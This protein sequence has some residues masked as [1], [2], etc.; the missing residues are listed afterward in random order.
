MVPWNSESLVLGLKCR[1]LVGASPFCFSCWQMYD[2]GKHARG[3][4]EAGG[5]GGCGPTHLQK[6]M[7]GRSVLYGVQ[8]LPHDAM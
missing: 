1:G 8:G 5:V 4:T 6:M 3:C 7:V 2:E